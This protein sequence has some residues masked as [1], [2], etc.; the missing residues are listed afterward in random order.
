M[1]RTAR[2]PG[3]SGRR[4]SGVQEH[5]VPESEEE[6]TLG[7]MV[8][9]FA[10][11]IEREASSNADSL[12]NNVAN[13][14]NI[15]SDS[16]SEEDEDSNASEAGAGYG[17]RSLVVRDE[18]PH[19]QIEI[20]LPSMDQHEKEQYERLPGF[21]IVRRVIEPVDVGGGLGYHVTFYD[22]H[23]DFVSRCPIA[24]VV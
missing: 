24:T 11:R 17:D 2:W 22:G 20:V 4:S 6:E 13:P 18:S 10:R 5:T 9:K 1:A 16:L 15:E 23:D 7:D 3:Q 19:L 21:D 8:N 12:G 14:V